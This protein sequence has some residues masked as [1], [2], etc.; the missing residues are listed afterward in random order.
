MV[1][2]GRKYEQ[3]QILRLQYKE[4][5]SLN[6]G[7]EI[8]K[9]TGAADRVPNITPDIYAAATPAEQGLALERELGDTGHNLLT[10]VQEYY[11]DVIRD[12]TSGEEA[13]DQVGVLLSNIRPV[14]YRGVPQEIFDAHKKAY[15]ANQ[16]NKNP[17]EAFRKLIREVEK[18]SPALVGLVY[19]I[20]MRSP[21]IKKAIVQQNYIIASKELNEKMRSYGNSQGYLTNLYERSEDR[22]KVEVALQYGRMYAALHEEKNEKS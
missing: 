2:S 4:N 21:D 9:I 17:D 5:P 8:A 14:E 13:L 20:S 1:N 6:I 7:Y 22:E 3:L 10:K 19:A 18:V 12:I 15:D 16:D 11:P